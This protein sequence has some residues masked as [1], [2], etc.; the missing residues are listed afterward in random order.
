[1]SSFKF[2]HAP[3]ANTHT[4][5]HTS[6][7]RQTRTLPCLLSHR[8]C[9]LLRYNCSL[10]HPKRTQPAVGA[11]VSVVDD[12]DD[13]NV[14]ENNSAHAHNTNNSTDTKIETII[15]NGNI[16]YLVV[17]GDCD[18]SIVGPPSVWIRI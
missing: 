7:K 2:Q 13:G 14:E 16:A 12:D 11:S 18:R 3:P 10:T 1:M 8:P 6:T 4:H 15:N 5:T 9:F 17:G